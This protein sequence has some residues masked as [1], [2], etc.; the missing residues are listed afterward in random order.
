MKPDDFTKCPFDSVTK[1]TTH[2]IA[3]A[4]LRGCLPEYCDVFENEEVA[5]ESL[6]FIHEV[7]P[8]GAER[9]LLIGLGIL[10]LDLKTHGNEYLQITDC[11]CGEPWIHQ[12]NLSPEEWRKENEWHCPERR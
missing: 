9:S 4:G 8:D 12:D 2:F 11:S 5:A 3:M 1:M 6:L 10:Y 7:S